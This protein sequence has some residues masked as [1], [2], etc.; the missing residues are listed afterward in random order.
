MT[1]A[2]LLPALG[3]T[4]ACLLVATALAAVVVHV[5]TGWFRNRPHP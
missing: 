2:T 1:P 4:V 5:A 3:L